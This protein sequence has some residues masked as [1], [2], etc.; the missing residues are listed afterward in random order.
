M[1]VYAPLVLYQTECSGQTK[2]DQDREDLKA[3]GRMLSY[4]VPGPRDFGRDFRGNKGSYVY[5]GSS[6]DVIVERSRTAKRTLFE[7][8][9][10]IS[11]HRLA[12]LVPDIE[13]LYS[14]RTYAGAILAKMNHK[15]G[16]QLLSMR[17]SSEFRKH[18]YYVP[19]EINPNSLASADGDDYKIAELIIQNSDNCRL[20]SE[21]RLRVKDEMDDTAFLRRLNAMETTNE[22]LWNM[23]RERDPTFSTNNVDPDP[24]FTRVRKRFENKISKFR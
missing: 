18:Q 14:D 5:R 16:V 1:G 24:S 22:E 15:F 4:F 13:M 3:C 11:L 9:S 23:L 6:V 12:I 21:S 7:T 2:T 19:A 10:R 8:M 20:I 17:F